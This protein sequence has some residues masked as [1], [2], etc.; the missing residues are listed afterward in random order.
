MMERLEKNQKLK[1]LHDRPKSKGEKEMKKTLDNTLE[2][3]TYSLHDSIIEKTINQLREKEAIL[4]DKICEEE[5]LHKQL[6]SD[7]RVINEKLYNKKEVLTNLKHQV[8]IHQ[9]EVE[10][11]MK[12]LLDTRSKMSELN[13]TIS[14]NKDILVDIQSQLRDLE[15][16]SIFAYESGEIEFENPTSL[17]I[18]IKDEWIDLF[19]SLIGYEEFEHLTLREL[20]QLSKLIALTKEL[21]NKKI[22]YVVSFDSEPL[23]EVFTK[24]TQQRCI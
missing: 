4:S 9:E 7:R 15:Q 17:K 21:H 3:E 8:E 18:S 5:F 23:Q 1:A 14:T 2:T 16:I 20:K 22:N 13:I 6:I 12:E 11:L 24:V 19:N 10:N